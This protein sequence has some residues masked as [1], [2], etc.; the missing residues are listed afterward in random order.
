VIAPPDPLES[1]EA[2]ARYTHADLRTLSLAD[3]KRE[4]G[5][6]HLHDILHHAPN[7]WVVQRRRLVALEL[8]A[9]EEN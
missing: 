2:A 9:R 8:L 3:L 5:R 1:A 7:P 4:A 6:L